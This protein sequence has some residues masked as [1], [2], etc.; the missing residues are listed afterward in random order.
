MRLSGDTKPHGKL[1]SFTENSRHIAY[2][3]HSNADG[4]KQG[5]C[6]AEKE[7]GMTLE[8]GSKLSHGDMANS[9]WR[10]SG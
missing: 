7:E 8:I 3:K 6:V 5:D 10:D 2:N 9:G 4:S 1:N